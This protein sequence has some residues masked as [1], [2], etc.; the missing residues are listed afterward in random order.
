MAKNTI[1]TW[2]NQVWENV[3]TPNEMGE[4]EKFVWET[5]WQVTQVLETQKVDW[6]TFL[7][8]VTYFPIV[9]PKT[10]KWNESAWQ[11]IAS[12]LEWS[13]EAQK[14]VNEAVQKYIETM[15]SW[16][17]IALYKAFNKS[18]NEIMR[19]VKEWLDQKVQKLMLG[20][21]EIWVDKIILWEELS[22]RLADL[23][24]YLDNI[25]K[26]EYDRLEELDV[27]KWRK[28]W[29]WFRWLFWW[30]KFRQFTSNVKL[31]LNLMK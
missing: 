22:V 15:N 25:W 20:W 10:I 21:D 2:I 14:A 16:S 24:A 28:L 9:D 30:N 18:I 29:E 8:E 27:K 23:Y 12:I 17:T 31:Q 11:L 19:W 6:L 26:L 3:K 4:T 7:Q 13:E 5:V 1:W